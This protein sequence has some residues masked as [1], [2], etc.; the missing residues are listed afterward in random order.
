MFVCV[1][2]CLF[3]EH[4]QQRID[5]SFLPIPPTSVL[6]PISRFPLLLAT[7]TPPPNL[8]HT[9]APSPDQLVDVRLQRQHLRRTVKKIADKEADAKAKMMQSMRDGRMDVAQVHAE[10]VMRQRME[11]ARTHRVLATVERL[12]DDMMRAMRAIPAGGKRTAEAGP[13][14]AYISAVLNDVRMLAACPATEL[15]GDE[16][17]RLIEQ[18]MAEIR[19]QMSPNSRTAAAVPDETTPTRQQDELIRRLNDLRRP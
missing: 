15:T 11:Q 7:P 9:D 5:Y 16:A 6:S 13:Q 12:Y 19:V 17:N 18:V 3:G 10:C 2:V 1:F 4:Y 14:A 8:P